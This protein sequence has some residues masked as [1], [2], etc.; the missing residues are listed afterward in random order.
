MRRLRISAGVAC[1]LAS[2]IYL[3][4]CGGSDE[5]AS[6]DTVPPAVDST[7]AASAPM[8]PAPPAGAVDVAALEK[9]LQGLGCFACH[10]V[11]EK[12]VGPSYR[13]IADKYRGAQGAALGLTMKVISGGGGAWG[14]VP[15]IAHP[16]LTRE[17]L[18]PLMERVLLIE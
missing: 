10:A 5:T 13:E 9:E 6:A 18:E 4:G 17:Q 14:P 1:V 16:H 2:G 12:R 8:E 7:T 3:S 11:N 15:M